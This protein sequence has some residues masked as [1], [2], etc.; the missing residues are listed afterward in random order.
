MIQ[1]TLYKSDLLDD[2]TAGVR[3]DGGRQ[4][5]ERLHIVMVTVGIILNHF[6]G[7]QLLETGFLSNLVFTLIGVMLQVADI[8]YVTH[9]THLVTKVQ[10]IAVEQVEGNSR[11]GVPQ[12][13][14]TIDGRT[15]Y[16]HANMPLV[17]GAEI[18]FLTG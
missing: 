15:A 3:L 10:E 11:T 8:G 17:Q 12:M 9:I 1:N 16:I 18:L 5:V 4:H 2:M 6:H 14:I 13:G 7:F